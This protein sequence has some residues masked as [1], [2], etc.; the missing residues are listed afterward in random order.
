[1]NRLKK[2]GES[3]EKAMQK[4]GKDTLIPSVLLSF[5]AERGGRFWCIETRKRKKRAAFS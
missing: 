3:A 1:M 4:H 2:Q 5:L